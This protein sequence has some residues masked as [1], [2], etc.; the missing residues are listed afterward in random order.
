MD[1]TLSI[2]TPLC[3]FA[4]SH[5]VSAPSPCHSL[6][7]GVGA[8]FRIVSVFI[9]VSLPTDFPS[10]RPTLSQWGLEDE[11][12]LL[13]NPKDSNSLVSARLSL[14]LGVLP[15]HMGLARVLPRTVWLIGNHVCSKIYPQSLGCDP[16]ASESSRRNNPRRSDSCRFCPRIRSRCCEASC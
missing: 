9:V 6:K 13:K 3:I 2:D 16:V 8:W 12:V 7:N 11:C 14:S 4:Y 1:Y 5:L 15:L 10:S